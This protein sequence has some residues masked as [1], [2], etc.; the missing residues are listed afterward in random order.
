MIT[1]L[2]E[3][4][5][6]ATFLI[7]VVLALRAAFGKR[8]SARLRYTL[9]LVVLVRLL[10]PVQLFTSPIA[11]TWV[12]TEQRVEHSETTLPTAPTITAPGPGTP[13]Q[14]VKDDTPGHVL[15]PPA[16]PDAPEPPAAPAAPDITTTSGW[17]GWIWLGGSAALTLVFL[18]SNLRFYRRLRRCRAPLE[19][20]DC[21]LQVYV[22]VG[23]PS[24]CLLGLVCP[25]VY[26]TPEVAGDP[27]M[28]RHVLAHEYTHFRHG[29]HL[30]NL[31][32]CTALAAHWW[33]P[34]VWVSAR[35]SQRDGELAC[36]EGA[37]KHLGDGER[38]AYGHTLLALVT[39]KPG[40]G[41]LLR[42]ATTM[43]GDKKS[44][45]ERI[46]R[47]ARAPR[48]WLW[49]AVAVVLVTAL[50]CAVAFG[51]A[52]KPTEQGENGKTELHFSIND[53]DLVEISGTVLGMTLEPG[54]YWQATGA[55]ARALFM[56][57]APFT[58]GIKGHITAWWETPTSISVTTYMMAVPSS[59][60]P[61]SYWNF[62]V[63]L[64]GETPIVTRME[65]PEGLVTPEDAKVRMYPTSI[66]DEEAIRAARYA[67]RLLS[68]AEDY[69][70]SAGDTLQNRLLDVPEELRADVVVRPYEQVA[71]GD[72]LVHYW[73][74]RDWTDLDHSGLGW[75][76]GVRRMSQG[77]LDEY[78]ATGGSEVFARGGGAYYYAI[79]YATDVRYYSPDDAES[80]HNAFDA[81]QAF[82]KKTV[83]DTQGVEP[84]QAAKS[85]DLNR[86]GV[87]EELRCASVDE[88]AGEKLEVWEDGEML[89]TE[90]GYSTHIGYNA[91]FLCTLDGEDYLLRYH[92]TMYQGY[93]TYN[94]QLFTLENGT[95]TVAR[96][97]GVDF[98]INFAPLMHQSF[99]P[100]AIAAFMDEI[101][102]LLENSVQLLNTDGDLL[103]SFEKEGRLYDGLWWLDERE[104]EFTRDPSKSLLENLRDFLTAMEA[105]DAPS[106]SP[107]PEQQAIQTV[108]DEITAAPGTVFTLYLPE[109]SQQPYLYQTDVHTNDFC[110]TQLDS[111][112]ERFQW[113][114]LEGEAA[115]AALMAQAQGTQLLLAPMSGSIVCL[116][117]YR[118]SPLV[119]IRTAENEME[120]YRASSSNP[121][122]PL[123]VQ[124]FL[125][126]GPYEAMRL[127]FDEVELAAHQNAFRLVDEREHQTLHDIA[128]EWAMNHESAL[129]KAAPGSMFACTYMDVRNVHVELD[130][131][132]NSRN[133]MAQR[134]GLDPEGY[135][136]T[137]FPFV[138]ETVFVPENQ[139]AEM[140]LTA[141]NTG[142]FTG[143]D[144]PEGA[145]TYSLCGIMRLT[146][147]GW[148]CDEVGT[149]W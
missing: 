132:D 92:P 139:S 141:G 16:L 25:A 136:T 144:A 148:T 145:L 76:L 14:P 47:I 20:T 50:A 43:V 108:M 105:G 2:L 71:D 115:G 118:D 13:G 101:N 102:G 147:D 123:G 56:P 97:G 81:I 34:L 6:T 4:V 44:L 49:A 95:Q 8:V 64:S 7:L 137:W 117:V 126:P 121:D 15:T 84:Y 51:Q 65:T 36:D 99:D 122:E 69:Y 40:P 58:D 30:W 73:L 62:T 19:G 143:D 45:K 127:V 79:V 11:G 112:A 94:Y 46:T 107:A 80:F 48:R 114:Q 119:A 60:Y 67:A 146:E 33:N 109:H 138:Y 89:F 28:L 128:A 140:Q 149:G 134:K 110:G 88:G 91:L 93:C 9:W 85:S 96:E 111:F 22:A 104:P 106:A 72:F 24:P 125:W 103:A 42:F 78:R 21:P 5:F 133:S 98:D 57:Y 3:W 17:L 12:V 63:D 32:R 55:P 61:S 29:D 31:L 52:E 53:N 27:A 37:L 87:P 131:P 59:Y 77:E 74:N 120:Y 54:T 130:W 18:G 26:V 39:A 41:D 124:P 10:V 135:G 129:V 70:N 86:N 1:M 68:S 100:E 82:A 66:S 75:L 113:E 38:H 35:L 90:E 116:Y 142:E 23:L 83:L